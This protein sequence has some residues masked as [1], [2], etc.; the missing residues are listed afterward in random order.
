M[1]MGQDYLCDFA[2]RYVVAWYS[3]DPAGVSA[4][5]AEAGSPTINVGSPARA[6]P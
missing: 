5:Y 2:A 4:C 1:R 6:D 3:Q